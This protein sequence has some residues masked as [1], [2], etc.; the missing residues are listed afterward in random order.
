MKFGM[1]RI[2]AATLLCGMLFA[3]TPSFAYREFPYNGTIIYEYTYENDMPSYTLSQPITIH[4]D[5][6][7]IPSDV[8]PTIRSG[9]TMVPL[10]AAGEALGAQVTWDQ[11]TQT[12]TAIKDNRVV[13]FRLN[14]QTFYVNGQA[15]H[16]DVAP[17]I[18]NNRT[19]LPLRVFAEAL[20]A[21]V[22]WDQ[23]LYDVQI[24]TL[25]TD[26]TAPTIPTD[27]TQKTDN[28]IK[29]YYVQ[30]DPD[31]TVVGSWRSKYTVPH[32]EIPEVDIT[33]D[34]TEYDSYKFVTK[35]GNNKYQTVEMT[36]EDYDLDFYS[37]TR[38]DNTYYAGDNIFYI[39]EGSRVYSLSAPRG[40]MMGQ[41]YYQ[42]D[43]N[44]MRTVIAYDTFG[45]PLRDDLNYFKT[46]PLTKF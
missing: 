3:P 43:N 27:V 9:R 34:G 8:D 4:V 42:V 33:P 17:T 44:T 45:N 41:T 11:G 25:A 31:D 7:Y 38:N 19:L 30:P 21:D 5:G 35:T 18:I 26:I 37:I 2:I 22:F 46:N 40:W 20:N 6:K 32:D 10:R 16:T 15:Q 12:A 13:Q 36:V 28:F 23:S 39:T 1:K 24:D 29:K 14:S